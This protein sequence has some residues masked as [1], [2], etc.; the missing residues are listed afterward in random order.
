MKRAVITVGLGFGDEGK[1]VAVDHLTRELGADLVVRYCGGS[2]AGHTVELPDGRRHTFSQFGAGTLAPTCPRTY[3]G[4]AVV[5]DPPAMFREA[6]HLVELGV[7]A[8]LRLVTVHPRCLVTTPWLKL[9]NRLRELSRGSDRHGSCGQGI[10]EA[11]TYW[12]RHGE[13][14]VFAADLR[15]PETLRHKLELQR[16]RVLLECQPLLATCPADALHDLGVDAW[17]S[18]VEEL[19]AELAGLGWGEVEIAPEVPAHRTMVLEGAQGVLLDEYRGLHPYTT[20]STVTPHHAWDVITRAGSD[21]VAVIGVTRAYTTRH[22]EGPLPTFSAELT[23]RL[24][25]PGNPWNRWQ[26]SIRC[27]W[28]DLPLLRYAATVCGPLD[29]LAVSHFDQF[30]GAECRVCEA[31]RGWAPDPAAVP[32]LAWQ[33]RLTER[34]RSAEPV[35]IPAD[36]DVI[37]RQLQAIAPVLATGRGP[38][39]R[40][41]TLTGLTFRARRA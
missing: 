35:L 39:H 18:G 27:G 29:G 37:T 10:A 20:W 2:Q 30:D 1:G 28:L 31:Y 17:E 38:T 11:R 5:I 15:T 24:A 7:P 25:D 21:A 34:V 32:N 9:L 4:P 23:A 41:R 12:L 22:G 14:A 33:E 6:Q 3:L 8:P 26:S 16:Q 13:D 36:P 19:A 40:D